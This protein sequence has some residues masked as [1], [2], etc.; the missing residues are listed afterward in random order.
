MLSRPRTH[1]HYFAHIVSDPSKGHTQPQLETVSWYEDEKNDQAH[2]NQH[3]EEQDHHGAF[4]HEL[5]DVRFSYTCP[6]HEG[7]FAEPRQ[8]EHRVDRVLLR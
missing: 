4:V 6:V 7:V 3:G 2:A 5:S 8:G 1:F